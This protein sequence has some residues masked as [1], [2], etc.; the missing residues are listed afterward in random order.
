MGALHIEI[1]M[2]QGVPS[3]LSQLKQVGRFFEGT[4]GII[5]WDT[6][7][8]QLH[9]TE[10]LVQCQFSATMAGCCCKQVGLV[11]SGAKTGDDS[12]IVASS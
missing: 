4:P 10:Q 12:E 11:F 1:M 2:V 9:G 8:S 5:G 3:N 6:Q 7:V